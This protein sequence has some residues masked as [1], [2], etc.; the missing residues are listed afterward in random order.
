MLEKTN[1]VYA[2]TCIQYYTTYYART[3]YYD[4]Y[5]S[6]VKK[7]FTEQTVWKVPIST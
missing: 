2:T 4:L 7:C 5:S 1:I 6:N 3:L